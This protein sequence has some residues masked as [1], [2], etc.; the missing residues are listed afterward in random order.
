MIRDFLKAVEE[1]REARKRFAVP[2]DLPEVG[3]NI[4]RLD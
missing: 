4:H 2:S 1:D 3:R